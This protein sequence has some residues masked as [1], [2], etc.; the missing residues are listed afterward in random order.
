MPTLVPPVPGFLKALVNTGPCVQKKK[1]LSCFLVK[2]LIK[3][4]TAKIAANTDAL[5]GVATRRAFYDQGEAILAATIEQDSSLAVI[6]FDLDTFKRAGDLG[7]DEV[8]EAHANA[9]LR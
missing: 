9:V 4:V 6:L 7:N 2:K 3:A 8:P 1:W 5:T